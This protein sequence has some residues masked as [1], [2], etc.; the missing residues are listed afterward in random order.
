MLL[1]RVIIFLIK[2]KNKYIV[3]PDTI[4]CLKHWVHD[5]LPLQENFLLWI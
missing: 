3:L 5:E 2:N 4:H 1:S